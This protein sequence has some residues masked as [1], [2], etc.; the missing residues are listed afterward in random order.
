MQRDLIKAFTEEPR[1]GKV[2]LVDTSATTTRE[3]KVV[4][5]LCV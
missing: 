1:L 2:I 4:D 5:W 3:K